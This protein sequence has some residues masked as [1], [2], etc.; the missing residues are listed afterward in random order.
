MI[1]IDPEALT[2]I[3]EK[4]SGIFI[5]A[6]R[7]IGGCCIEITECPSVSFGEPRV[8][9]GYTRQTIQGVTTYV[10]D[11]FPEHGDFVIRVGRFLGFRWLRL[12]GWRLA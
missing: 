9:T 10:P 12:D 3:A 8:Q 6:P 2:L 11:C 7:A 5:D 1:T 4:K